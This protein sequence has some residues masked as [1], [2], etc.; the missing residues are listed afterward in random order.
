MAETRLDASIFD[1][2]ATSFELYTEINGELR[3]YSSYAKRCHSQARGVA[4]F[5]CHELVVDRC[6]FAQVALSV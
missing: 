6:R 2:T 5:K 4:A 1:R 3:I